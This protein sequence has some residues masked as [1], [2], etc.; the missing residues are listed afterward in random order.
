MFSGYLK[1][2][3]FVLFNTGMAIFISDVC[4]K[5]RSISTKHKMKEKTALKERS[6]RI[7]TFSIK[8]K[9]NT[10]P[11]FIAESEVKGFT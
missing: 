7:Y 5:E 1:I 4:V 8:N 2:A 6:F 3:F 10:G 9:K 11:C